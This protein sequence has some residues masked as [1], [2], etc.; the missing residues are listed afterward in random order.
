MSGP[1]LWTSFETWPSPALKENFP[2]MSCGGQYWL[3]TWQ[4]LEPSRRQASGNVCESFQTELTELGR[5]TLDV[6]GAV[7]WAWGSGM[8]EK[9]EVS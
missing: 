9:E 7:P 1:G 2:L 4:D 5:P 8:N 3:A 6:G